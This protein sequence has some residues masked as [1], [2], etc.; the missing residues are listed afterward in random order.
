MESRHKQQITEQFSKQL[1]HKKLF[2]LDIPD[3]Y[4]YMDPELIELLQL[5]IR[6]YLK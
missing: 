3:E 4:H 5:A 1:L 2:V 6:P